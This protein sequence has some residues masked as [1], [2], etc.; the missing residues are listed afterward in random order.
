MAIQIQNDALVKMWL[1]ILYGSLWKET[2]NLG[3]VCTEDGRMLKFSNFQL[4]GPHENVLM[5]NGWLEWFSG[6]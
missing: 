4:Y 5:P 1:V 2:M 3:L 6:V